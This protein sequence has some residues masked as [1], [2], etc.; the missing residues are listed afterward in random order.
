MIKLML[1]E[2]VVA[3]R[4]LREFDDTS[5]PT[6]LVHD[7]D[8]I[9]RVTEAEVTFFQKQWHNLLEELG[10]HRAATP[11]EI[12]AGLPEKVLACKTE[13]MP[14]FLRRLK[15]IEELPID[16]QVDPLD[17]SKFGDAPMTR[18]QFAILRQLAT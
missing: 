4:T 12:K 11:D 9:L 3:D 13:N 16:L 8:K 1:G 18:K 14:E 7:M 10:E 2:V 6:S 5:L 15:E 17:I